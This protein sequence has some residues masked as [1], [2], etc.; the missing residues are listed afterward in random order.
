MS[1]VVDDLDAALKRADAKVARRLERIVREALALA[2]VPSGKTDENGWPEGYFEATA[3]AL[4]DEPFERPPQLP[5][6]QR[7]TW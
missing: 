3:G 7:E 1:S 6:E 5:F 2:D 4:G